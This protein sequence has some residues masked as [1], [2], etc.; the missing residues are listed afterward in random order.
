M[1]AIGNQT[2][3]HLG[4]GEQCPHE[5]G[6]AMVKGGHGIVQM[7]GAGDAGLK[8]SQSLLVGCQRV[9][10]ADHNAAPAQFGDHLVGARQFWG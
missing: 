7:G 3:R 2:R 1:D 6:S 9:T 8:G 10:G 4:L 5:A